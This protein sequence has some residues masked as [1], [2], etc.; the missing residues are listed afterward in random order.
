MSWYGAIAV[1]I[2][3]VAATTNTFEQQISSSNNNNKLLSY[4]QQQSSKIQK[5]KSRSNQIWDAPGCKH[6]DY[7]GDKQKIYWD[8]EHEILT[9]LDREWS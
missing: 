5:W 9:A 4:Q 8:P 1:A 3:A 2:A 6:S 7:D